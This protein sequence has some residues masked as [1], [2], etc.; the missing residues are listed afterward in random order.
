M[1]IYEHQHGSACS[2]SAASDDKTCSYFS[3]LLFRT[4]CHF[5]ELVIVHSLVYE[6]QKPAGLLSLGVIEDHV[7]WLGL[8]CNTSGFK[9]VIIY[10]EIVELEY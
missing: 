10:C 6:K 8:Q 3:Y 4:T 7:T 2:W 1:Y 5:N 9:F